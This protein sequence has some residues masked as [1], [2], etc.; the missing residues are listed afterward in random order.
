[1]SDIIMKSGN[2]DREVVNYWLESEDPIAQM[3][4]Y[5]FPEVIDNRESIF[6]PGVK[7][8]PQWDVPET[9]A[10]TVGITGGMNSKNTNP[11]HPI[12][13][14]EI[15]KEALEC[16][17]AGA[18][19]IHVH[20]RDKNGLNVLRAAEFHK[21][22]DPIREKYPE[23][24]VCGC[25][26]PCSPGDYDN[27][28]EILKEGLFD[29]TPINCCA[30]YMG[31]TLFVK[32]PEL[33]MK[34]AELCAENKVKAQI[35]VYSDG[36]IDNARRYLINSGLVEKPYV[37]HILAGLPGT[38]PMYS[39][40]SMVETLLH[41]VKLI[42]E[43]DPDSEIMVTAS[44]RGGTYQTALAL[45]LGL[46]VRVGKEDTTFKYPN[47]DEY[48][49]RN[50]DAYKDTVAM[51]KILGRRPCTPAEHIKKYGLYRQGGK[52]IR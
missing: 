44:G 48:L 10:I 33:M 21:I 1:M 6:V 30:T 19:N 27:M 3:R 16:C 41:N 18:T 50:V 8:Q 34:K 47:S 23:V 35:A 39:P 29:Q 52:I 20:A 22:I 25:A 38:S 4:L 42:R 11:Y 26:V 49:E 37:W 13:S 2:V 36:D 40:M 12:T 7:I 32:S 51:A 14:E 28:E 24:I 5:G 31:D 9:V 46:N 43:I 17:E 15:L 45:L